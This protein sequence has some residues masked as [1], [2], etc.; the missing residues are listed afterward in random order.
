MILLITFIFCLVACD[1]KNKDKDSK[2][3]NIETSKQEKA[4]E[5]DVNAGVELVNGLPMTLFD[6]GNEFPLTLIDK[7]GSES[8]N[9]TTSTKYTDYFEYIPIVGETPD[10]EIPEEEPLQKDEISLYAKIL[11]GTVLF[12]KFVIFSAQAG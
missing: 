11:Y 9:I 5:E 8:F 6:K 3:E 12:T 10:I 1:Y 4:K 2:N 7:N